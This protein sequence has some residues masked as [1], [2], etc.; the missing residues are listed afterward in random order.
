[1]TLSRKKEKKRKRGSVELLGFLVIAVFVVGLVWLVAAPPSNPNP[2]QT[3]AVQTSSIAAD[4]TLT[5]VNGNVFK[6]SDNR[7]KVVVLEFMRTTCGACIEQEPRLRELR[8]RFGIDVVTVMISVDPA[9]DT[10]ELL[11]QHRDQNMAGWIAIRDTSGVYRTYGVQ[12]T[13]TIFII[14]KNGQVAYQ[15]VGV[16]ES[17]VLINEV[18]SL[19]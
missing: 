14:D 3:T 1:M 9:G 15:H 2:G 19:S 7:G 18:K 12:A 13:P 5:D 16:T 4:F 17:S 6:L 8:S 10:E 11:R